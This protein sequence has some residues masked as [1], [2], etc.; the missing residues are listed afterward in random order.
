MQILSRNR[1]VCRHVTHTVSDYGRENIKGL[2]VEFAWNL[3]HSITQKLMIYSTVTCAGGISGGSK[4]KIRY[5]M[6][7]L[8]DLRVSGYL[9]TLFSMY[10][11]GLITAAGE[12][13]NV[14]PGIRIAQ[15]CNVE[16]GTGHSSR[17]IVRI[18]VH[19]SALFQ[20]EE[21]NEESP[22]E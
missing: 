22:V 4:F 20:S 8:A 11:N 21:K 17:S 19:R 7:F 14:P 9:P 15:S 1:Q 5:D 6:D 13:F 10:A 3:H 12:I 16:I 18:G 2:C